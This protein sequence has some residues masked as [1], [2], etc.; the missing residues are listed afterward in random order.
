MT[1]LTKERVAA[2]NASYKDC[3]SLAVSA[4][5]G[6]AA[7]RFVGPRVRRALVSEQILIL[8]TIQDESISAETVRL[9]ANELRERLNN[10]QSLE[11]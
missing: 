9:I 5:G 8:V 3:V 2:L 1:E 4:A 10:D 7:F 6:K 11:V